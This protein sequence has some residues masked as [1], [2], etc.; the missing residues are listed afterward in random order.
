MMSLLLWWVLWKA[1]NAN[2]K[3]N[4][5]RKSEGGAM[6]INVEWINIEIIQ[7]IADT[8]STVYFC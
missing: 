2:A 4:E 6:M 7:K 3:N 5:L 8:I 1:A